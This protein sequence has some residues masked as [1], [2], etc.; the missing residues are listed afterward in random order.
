MRSNEAFAE[1]LSV[2]EAGCGDLE[3]FEGLQEET[4]AS[5]VAKAASIAGNPPNDA[6]A[7]MAKFMGEFLGAA[8]TSD[9]PEMC[10][11]NL[12]VIGA[13]GNMGKVVPMAEV[14]KRDVKVVDLVTDIDMVCKA[15]SSAQEVSKVCA[16]GK[17]VPMSLATSFCTAAARVKD[18]LSKPYIVGLN[19]P[20]FSVC[21]EL[22]TTTMSKLQEVV[23]QQTS[24][25][26]RGALE[27]LRPIAGGDLDGATWSQGFS[28]ASIADLLDFAKGSLMKADGNKVKTCVMNLEREVKVY[29]EVLG[30]FEDDRDT[31]ERR[32]QTQLIDD[33]LAR[34]KTTMLEAIIVDAIRKHIQTPNPVKLKGVA[35]KQMATASEA[36]QHLLHPLLRTATEDAIA[37]RFVIG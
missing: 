6:K 31:D 34:A 25:A 15:V 19:G 18:I 30:M 8:L 17:A 7:M 28:S 35:R 22:M 9:T 24:E 33:T 4:A 16:D 1:V 32:Q 20:W 29:T 12:E 21:Q 27:L 3:A 5:I 10:T 36:V 13:C 37:F 2:C 23:M 14:H 26:M 11:M